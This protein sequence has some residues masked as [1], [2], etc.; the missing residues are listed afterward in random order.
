MF[1]GFFL[2]PPVSCLQK[3]V[4]HSRNSPA[5][6][7]DLPSSAYYVLHYLQTAKNALTSNPLLLGFELVYPREDKKDQMMTLTNRKTIFSVSS[8]HDKWSEPS[9]VNIGLKIVCHNQFCCCC[10]SVTP[11]AAWTFTTD[12]GS[13]QFVQWSKRS[14]VVFTQ[15]YQYQFVK[16]NNN[17][18]RGSDQTYILT[19]WLLD[20]L[21]ILID[22]KPAKSGI[23]VSFRFTT[24]YYFPNHRQD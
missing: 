6:V 23:F 11:A 7:S 5:I 22:I 15:I 1:T 4:R 9:S 2:S 3:W 20:G 24:D 8:V 19:F 18:S 12:R 16:T 17:A 13:D 10:Y 21:N 14:R